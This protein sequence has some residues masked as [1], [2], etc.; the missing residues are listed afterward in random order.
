VA[1]GIALTRTVPV[2]LAARATLDTTSRRDFIGRRVAL[3][4]DE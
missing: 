3:P 2:A 1:R 4:V